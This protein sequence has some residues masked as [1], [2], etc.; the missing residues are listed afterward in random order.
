MSEAMP[1]SNALIRADGVTLAYPGKLV[2]R[3]LRLEIRAGEF[4]CLLGANGTGKTSLLRAIL[5]LLPVQSGR[6]QFA[7]GVSAASI[8]FVP[9]HCSWSRTVPT[10]VREFVSLG[11]VG[12][13][14]G[15][16]ERMDR[17]RRALLTVALDDLEGNDLWSL[18]G[19]QR[20]RAMIARG[21]VRE[22]RILLL[23]EPTA[24]LDPAAEGSL[25][26]LVARVNGEAGVTVLLVTHDLSVADRYA[27]HVAL[28]HDG[29]VE[30]GP[31]ADVLRHDNLERI[32]GAGSHGWIHGLGEC[33]S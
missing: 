27:T 9:Q 20:Q 28:F 4:W 33:R 26:A 31:R 18:S 19:G 16:A 21:L 23:D 24:S 8:G 13:R 6:L 30:V 29:E 15:A 11:T 17:L 14:L 25:L 10:T 5:G 1:A 2:V 7:A 3:D 22:P 12:L 32:Y